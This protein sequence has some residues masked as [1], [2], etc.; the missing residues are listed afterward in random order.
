M[1]MQTRLENGELRATITGPNPTL[2]SPMVHLET[3]R[4]HYAVLR[5][6]Y[7]GNK[8]FLNQMI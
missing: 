6:M 8:Y 7:Y 2:D 5:M 3:T 4:R 1:H